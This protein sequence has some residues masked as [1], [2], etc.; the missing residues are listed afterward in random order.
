MLALAF[1][2]QAQQLVNISGNFSYNGV[3]KGNEMISII[4]TGN[5]SITPIILT[6]TVYT[7]SL[8]NY[9]SSALL[10]T[11]SDMGYVLLKTT[12]CFGSVQDAYVYYFPG[13]YNIIQNFTCQ[14]TCNN[15]FIYHVDSAS[16]GGFQVAFSAAKVNP[17]C[18]Y[19]WIFGDGSTGTGVNPSHTYSQAGTYMVSLTTLD[20]V[21]ACT[22]VYTD[23]IFVRF[24]Y[25]N[26]FTT[27]TYSPDSVNSNTIN[28][29]ANGLFNPTSIITWDMGDNTILLGQNVQHTYTNAGAYN[30]CVTL[31]DTFNF[32]YSIYC[33]VV[34][35]GNPLVS[36]CNA[37]F[38]MFMI[39]D[40]VNQGA[41]IVYFGSSYSSPT[42]TYAWDFGDGNFSYG[43]SNVLHVFAN[44]GIYDV[45]AYVFDPIANCA[46]TVCKKIELIDG[47]MRIL[48]LEENKIIEINSIF[49]NPTDEI[50][51]VTLTSLEPSVAKLNI[52]SIDGRLLAQYNYMLELGKNTIQVDVSGLETGLYLVEIQNNKSSVAS[53]LLVR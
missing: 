30:V 18:S 19:S 21:N 42:S 3:P 11:F 37:D 51:Y 9:S 17:Q 15:Y 40:S 14:S 28:L 53:K 34:F 12:D 16:N 46:D 45:C 50:S 35:A 13:Y 39:P 4:Y 47:N 22:S 38:K 10:P 36:N 52:R 25:T 32:C 7:D 44:S 24:Y 20:T 27:F 23:S 6:D 48:G 43:T 26:C 31:I 41:N 33:D 2:A 29:S 1:T 8:G 5:D 49:P